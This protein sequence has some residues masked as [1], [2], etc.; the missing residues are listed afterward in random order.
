MHTRDA[1]VVR[2]RFS[3][4]GQLVPILELAGDAVVFRCDID[5]KLTLAEGA[6][7][8][9]V[10]NHL[11]GWNARFAARSHATVVRST[12]EYQRPTAGDDLPWMRCESCDLTVVSSFIASAPPFE[13][14]AGSHVVLEHSNVIDDFDVPAGAAFRA[15]GSLFELDDSRPFFRI[16][17]APETVDVHL[18]GNG[19]LRRLAPLATAFVGRGTES[20]S[21]EAFA[22]LPGVV[23]VDNRAIDAVPFEASF[24]VAAT[25]VARDAD[26]GPFPDASAVGVLDRFGDCRYSDGRADIG[27]DELTV[28]SACVP[29]DR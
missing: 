20:L 23:S 14:T 2:S 27:A 4:D 5:V 13:M 29:P 3:F 21:P 19:F 1:F 10:E 16:A 24:C 8:T 18:R 9:L 11:G 17:V 12:V 22:A 7:A 15:F 28:G 26:V 6:T 25:S